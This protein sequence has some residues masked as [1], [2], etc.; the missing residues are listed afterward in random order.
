MKLQIPTPSQNVDMAQDLIN[1]FEK[2]LTSSLA[3]K[4]NF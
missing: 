2:F 4:R 3:Y 1:L